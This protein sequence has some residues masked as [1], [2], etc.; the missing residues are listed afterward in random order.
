MYTI[1]C[2]SII[3]QNTV[4]CSMALNMSPFSDTIS[5]FLMYTHKPDHYQN[6]VVHVAVSSDFLWIQSQQEKPS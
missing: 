6:T 3:D 4:M 5:C 2:M 1:V